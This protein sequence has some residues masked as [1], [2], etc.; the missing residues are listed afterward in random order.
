MRARLMGRSLLGIC[1]VALS[2]AS[3]SCDEADPPTTPSVIWNGAITVESFTGTVPVG[4]T[5]FFSFVSPHQ[6]AVSLTLLS[7]I[8][9]GQPSEHTVNIGIGAPSGTG[10]AVGVNTLTTGPG[11]TAQVT[12][13]IPAGTYCARILDVGNLTAPATFAINISHPAQ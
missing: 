2:L 3:V 4:T 6:G 8:E 9:D 13:T 12:A 10:C 11:N 5:R 1:L 7:L